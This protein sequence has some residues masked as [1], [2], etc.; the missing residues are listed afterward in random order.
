MRLDREGRLVRTDIWREG[1]YLDLW[2]VPH[3][4]S[5]MAVAFGLF[6]FAFTAKAAFVIAFLL[7]VAYE[8][9][10][11]IAKIEETRWNRILDVV[12]GM[13]SFTPTFLL[14]PSVP[15]TWAVAAFVVVVVADSV[16]SFFGWRASQKAA[17]L[18]RSL[19]AE[20]EKERERFMLQRDRLRERWSNRRGRKDVPEGGV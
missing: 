8:M 9:F 13:A 4:L 17:Q 15:R 10:E 6:F 5:G 18:E 19:R 16:L 11:V 3:F 14:L 12:V 7:L 1:K 2:S 20:F